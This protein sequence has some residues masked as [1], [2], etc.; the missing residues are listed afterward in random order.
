MIKS[1]PDDIFDLKDRIIV[2]TGGLGQL[3]MQYAIALHDKGAKI[4]ILDYNT[5]FNINSSKLKDINDE[6]LIFVSAD[7]TNKESLKNA[8][9]QILEVWGSPY[10]L[11]NN[12]ALDSPPNSDSSENGPFEDYPVESFEKIMDV[13]VKGVFLASQIFGNQMAK[14]SKG[15]ILNI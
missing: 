15:S 7:V 8:L 6:N 9:R 13:N 12:A 5:D 11:I 14:N 10:G 4:V 3:G 2:I 1:E